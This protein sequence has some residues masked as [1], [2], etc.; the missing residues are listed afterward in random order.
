MDSR[1][2]DG[3]LTAQGGDESSLFPPLPL[4]YTQKLSDTASFYVLLVKTR[5]Q[6]SV[7]QFLLTTQKARMASKCTM[8]SYRMWKGPSQGSVE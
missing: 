6:V 7:L 2:E 4:R 3:P 1:E 8:S 5:V